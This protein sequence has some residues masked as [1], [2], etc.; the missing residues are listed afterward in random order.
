MSVARFGNLI[1]NVDAALLARFHGG[2]LSVTIRETLVAGPV[3]AYAAVPEATPLAIVGSW[4]MLEIAVRD[5]SA[6]DYFAAAT[7]TPVT[8][9]WE[10]G[11][12]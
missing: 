3:A 6:A 11:N 5:G 10:A 9:V 8:V 2:H 1:T 12:L 4:G 7:G